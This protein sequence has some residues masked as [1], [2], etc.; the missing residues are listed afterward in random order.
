MSDSVQ[1]GVADECK[2]PIRVLSPAKIN[3]TLRVVGRRPDGF[4]EIS[5]LVTPVTLYDELEVHEHA[6]CGVVIECDMPG[7]PTGERNLVHRA[8]E[9]LASRVQRPL[10]VRCRLTKRIPVGGGLGGGS[11]NAAAALM[12]LNQQWELRW[13]QARLAELAA[14]LGSDVPLFLAGGS[15]VMTGRGEQVQPTQLAW[16]G[17]I[18]L[19]MPGFSV[20]TGAVYQAWRQGEKQEDRPVE[21]PP[22]SSTVQWLNGTF[23]MLEAPAIEVCPELGRIQQRTAKLAGRPVRIS[24][25]GST[26]F[27][28]F[29]TYEEAST[30]ARVAAESLGIRTEVVQPVG[31]STAEVA[32]W[33]SP[34]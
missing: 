13:P 25:S 23:N 19:L 20:A 18:V 16:H 9:L 30:Y 10:R 5:S 11:S 8:V 27:T 28:A 34:K 2:R 12:A 3:W 22:A 7:V 15:V 4:H 21:P 32:S 24:G 33:K 26:L 17:W 14:E 6:E 29:D 31:Q 1:A